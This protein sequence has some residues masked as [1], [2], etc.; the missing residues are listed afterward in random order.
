M[1]NIRKGVILILAA[2]MLFS[3]SACSSSNPP[4]AA[5]TTPIPE[6]NTSQTDVPVPADTIPDAAA[7]AIDAQLVLLFTDMGIWSQGSSAD[8]KY[9]VTDLDHNGRLELIAAKNNQ[10]DRTTNVRIWETGSDGKSLAECKVQD[11][12]GVF[13]DIITESSDTFYT[14]TKDE[15]E[16]FFYDNTL[17]DGGAKTVKCSVQLKNGQLSVTEYA[18]EITISDPNGQTLVA[19]TDLNGIEISAEAYNDAGMDNFVGSMRGSTNL[20][21]FVISEVYDVTRL[22]G[23]F[24]VF[25]GEKQPPNPHDAP[26]PTPVPSSEPAPAPTPT[27]VPTPVPI[28]LTITKN[29]TNEYRKEGETA[30]FVATANTFTSLRW[31]MVSPD[32]GEYNTQTFAYLFPNAGVTGDYSTTLS[33]SSVTTGMSGWGAYCTFYLNDQTARTTTAYLNV[34]PTPAPTPTPGGHVSGTVSGYSYSTVS[35]NLSSG[36]AITVNRSICEEEGSI[37]IGAECDCYYVWNVGQAVYNYV[38]IKG[39][40]QVGPIYGSMSGTVTDHSNGTL[41][42]TLQNGDIVFVSTDLMNLVSGVLKD[43]CFCT[44]YFQNYA[45]SD[46]IYK[47]DVIGANEDTGFGGD[48]ATGFGFG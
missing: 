34:Q 9:T 44:V 1:K 48:H 42:I 37:Y 5:D 11:S 35:I 30:Y 46:Y 47:V 20:D 31:T 23:S 36:G 45:R 43:G 2:A 26:V 8:W 17:F 38:H 22:T 27:P 6:A 16:Y 29:P 10:A 15:W 18:F 40:Q 24:R 41:T 13:P 21:W 32:G 28:Y 4:S 25:T 33:I 7:Q 3:L 19:H 39:R 14:S 12:N